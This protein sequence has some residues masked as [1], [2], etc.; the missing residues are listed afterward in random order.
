MDFIIKAYN[1][2]TNL[3]KLQ[4]Q[5]KKALEEL[6][7]GL[8]ALQDQQAH[9]DFKPSFPKLNHKRDVLHGPGYDDIYYDWRNWSEKTIL[10]STRSDTPGKRYYMTALIS[11]LYLY[12]FRVDVG[13]AVPK[14]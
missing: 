3:I 6:G 1:K 7:I 14:K 13:S 11:T 4:K 5:K 12:S 8:H 9:G 10:D 2:D